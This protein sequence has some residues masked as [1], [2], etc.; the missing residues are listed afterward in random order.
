M[1]IIDLRNKYVSDN[2]FSVMNNNEVDE[3]WFF[4]HFT[5]YAEYDIY[6]KVVSEDGSYAD[7]IKIDN[8]DISIESGALLVKWVMESEATEHNK[9]FVQLLFENP[10][11]EEIAQDRVVNIILG[12]SLNVDERISEH[13]PSILTSLQRQIN[14]LERRVDE[15][16]NK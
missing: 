10:N 11:G 2:H 12:K 3:V 9:L 13:Y 6:L 15:L 16:E 5:Q 4:S 8:N 7:K 14:E 1:F